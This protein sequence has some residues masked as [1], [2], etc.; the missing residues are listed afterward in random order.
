MQDVSLSDSNMRWIF[1]IRRSLVVGWTNKKDHESNAA[2]FKWCSIMQAT[3]PA[4]RT[5]AVPGVFAAI[6][7][8]DSALFFPYDRDC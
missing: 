1:H 8:I 6:L 2:C 5:H 3:H 7:S 4:I